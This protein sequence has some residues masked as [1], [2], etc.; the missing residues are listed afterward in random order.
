MMYRALAALLW[1]LVSASFAGAAQYY[2]PIMAAGFTPGSTDQFYVTEFLVN[3]PGTQR[4]NAYLS[5]YGSDGMPLTVTLRFVPGT[6]STSTQTDNFFEFTIP[7]NGAWRAY[8]NETGTLKTGWVVL[9]TDESVSPVTV[10]SLNSR[11]FGLT[12]EAS[13][14]ES[15]PATLQR[16]FGDVGQRSAFIPQFSDPA[17]SDTGMAIANPNGGPA[18]VTIRLLDSSGRTIQS[19]RVTLQPFAFISKFLKEYFPS[20]ASFQGTVEVQ[21]DQPVAALG[22]RFTGAVFTTIPVTVL[23]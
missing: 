1:L 16:I 19:A 13:V 6:G 23:Q 17:A 11:R 14:F 20:L 2:F 5:F 10:F 12:S 8:T 3:N 15:F 21:S 7:G 18:N 22:L 4:V 9:D